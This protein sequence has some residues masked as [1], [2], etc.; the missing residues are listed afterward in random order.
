MRPEGNLAWG[1]LDRQNSLTYHITWCILCAAPTTVRTCKRN[2]WLESKVMT[3][4]IVG[5][6]KAISTTLNQM[7]WLF[8][9]WNTL[10][11]HLVSVE[12]HG[13]QNCWY[14]QGDELNHQSTKAACGALSFIFSPHGWPLHSFTLLCSCWLAFYLVNYDL[15]WSPVFQLRLVRQGALT[16]DLTTALECKLTLNKAAIWMTCTL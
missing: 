5:I 15:F 7:R 3:I 10:E 11:M 13:S 6:T 9:L 4:N 16:S 2:I 12:G 14:H 8:V 1:N